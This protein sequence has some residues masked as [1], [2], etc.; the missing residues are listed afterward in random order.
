MM[1]LNKNSNSNITGL[2]ACN[3][4]CRAAVLIWCSL[5]WCI[6]CRCTGP[7]CWLHA[8]THPLLAWPSKTESTTASKR[9]RHPTSLSP[10]LRAS[11]FTHM[12]GSFQW[13]PP[14]DTKSETNLFQQVRG[15]SFCDDKQIPTRQH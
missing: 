2:A 11:D 6:A 12:P 3:R 7:G 14:S 4:A 5:I 1:L 10:L 13:S 8:Y 15:N 9:P